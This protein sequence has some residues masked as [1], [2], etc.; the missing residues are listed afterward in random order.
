VRSGGEKEKRGHLTEQKSD[1]EENEEKEKRKTK[2]VRKS[3]I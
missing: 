1:V 3:R 2:N